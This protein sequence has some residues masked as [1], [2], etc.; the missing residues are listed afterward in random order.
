MTRS[1]SASRHERDRHDRQQRHT[2]VLVQRAHPSW[3]IMYGPWSRRF[4][5]YAT[6]PAPPGQGLVLSAADPHDL[7]AQIR[8]AEQAAVAVRS[9][10]RPSVPETQ[11]HRRG[12]VRAE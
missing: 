9:P 2:A 11:D 6:L 4:W 10:E 12:R 1:Q 7:T 8:D 3:L 5:A